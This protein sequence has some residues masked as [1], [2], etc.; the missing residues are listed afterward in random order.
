MGERIA[1][2]ETF[3]PFYLGE[4]RLPKTRTM[5]FI[6]TTGALFMLIATAITGHA[7]VLVPLALVFGYGFAWVSH[8][9]M[10]MNRP[11][12]FKYPLWSFIADCKLW[13]MTLTGKMPGEMARLGLWPPMPA[14]IP[15]KLPGGA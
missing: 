5:H 15:S 7:A 3:W 9:F 11:A 1:D 12:S 6:G 2:F 4:H 13:F 8:F 10:E 14:T